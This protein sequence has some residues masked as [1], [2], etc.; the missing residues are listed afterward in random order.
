MLALHSRVHAVPLYEAGQELLE[1]FNVR[2]YSICF[3]AVIHA[4]SVR[5]VTLSACLGS[6]RPKRLNWVS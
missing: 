4:L 5:L 3:R 6:V 1:C 2:M